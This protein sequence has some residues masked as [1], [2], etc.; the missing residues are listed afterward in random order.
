MMSEKTEVTKIP[1]SQM[2]TRGQL[3][4]INEAIYAVLMGSQSYTIGSRK[5]TRADL[6]QLYKMRKELESQVAADETAGNGFFDDCYV[7]VWPWER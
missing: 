2:D 4:V 3:A 5:I 7:A 6:G 1:F